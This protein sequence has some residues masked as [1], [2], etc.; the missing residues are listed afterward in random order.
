MQTTSNRL[1]AGGVEPERGYGWLG[2]VIPADARRFRV[3]DPALAAALSDAGAE[4]TEVAPDVEIAPVGELHGDAPVSI[5]VLGRPRRSGRSF[6]IRAGR[7]LISSVRVRFAV[8]RACRAVRRLGYSSVLVLTWDYHQTLRNQATRAGTRSR[9]PLPEYLPER[10]LVV[11]Q[12]AP[13]TRLLLDAVLVEAGRAIGVPLQADPPSIRT[14]LLIANAK[15]GMLRVAIGFGSRQIRNQRAAL[16]TLQAFGAP[17]LVAERVPWQLAG[18]RCGLAEWSLE[19]RLPGSR[20]KHPVSGPLL[21]DCVDFLVALHSLPAADAQRSTLLEQAEIV[22][23]AT[24]PED[25]Q[26]L[27]AL[28][29]RL[30]A[31]LADVPRGFAHGDFFH[32]NLLVEGGRLLGVV[33]WDAAGVGRLPLLDLLHLRH[34]THAVPEVDWGPRLVQQLLPWARAGG[35]E[36]A[37]DYCQRLG[38]SLHQKRLEALTFAYW[39]DRV[40]SQLRSQVHRL[41]QPVWLERNISLVLRVSS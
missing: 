1:A 38:F 15:Q 3:T 39:L 33:D 36:V 17:P 6:P 22:A 14:G 40:S 31:D 19:R 24:P 26:T 30:E 21:T 5:A 20:A 18:G 35:D 34:A 10:A 11:G 28:A 12:R 32:G 9:H 27:Q 2:A 13:Q 7:R 37:R 41:A 23:R 4:L 29:E 16:A 25:A 8:G